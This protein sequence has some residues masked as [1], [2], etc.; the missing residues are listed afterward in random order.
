M[1][2]KVQGEE[3]TIGHVGDGSLVNSE[4]DVESTADDFHFVPL[5]VVQ[6]TS[7][8]HCCVST[9]AGRRT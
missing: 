3:V 1:T 4:V 2:I 6:Q 8:R 5:V 7:S 9:N